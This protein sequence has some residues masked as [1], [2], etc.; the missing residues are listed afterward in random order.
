MIL[1]LELCNNVKSTLLHIQRYPLK[2][3]KHGLKLKCALGRHSSWQMYYEESPPNLVRES[4]WETETDV[5][6]LGKAPHSCPE[7]T[8]NAHMYPRV[9]VQNTERESSQSQNRFSET[10]IIFFQSLMW[11][12]KYFWKV[13]LLRHDK[14]LS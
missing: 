6:Y 2:L 14:L 1:W 10:G 7:E 11:G 8:I 9:C 3:H 12:K 4:K 13:S 5:I